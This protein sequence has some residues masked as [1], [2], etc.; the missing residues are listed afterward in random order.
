MEN[1]HARIIGY[2]PANRGAKESE[3][4]TFVVFTVD[5]KSVEIEA[6]EWSAVHG[7]LILHDVER[8]LVALF[9]ADR[10]IS[11]IVKQ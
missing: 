11:C 3:M 8:S 2:R 10:W 4:K 9:A 7:V 5:D 1:K 6:S